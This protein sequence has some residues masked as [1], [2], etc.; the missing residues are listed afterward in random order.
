[1]FQINDRAAEDLEIYFKEL[2]EDQIIYLNP[3]PTMAV[4]RAMKITGG[5]RIVIVAEVEKHLV[6]GNQQHCNETWP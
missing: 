3:T 4:D 5:R 2:R 1:M 6:I